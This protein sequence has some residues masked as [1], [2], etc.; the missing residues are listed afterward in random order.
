M[1]FLIIFILFAPKI[2]AQNYYADIEITV[3]EAGNV[4]IQ[5]TSNYPDLI[6][7]NTEKYTYKKQSY[8]LL[9]ITKEEVFSDYIYT[10]NLPKGSKINY[11]ESSGFDGIEE[12][13]GQLIITGSGNDEK[14]SIL[15]QYQIDGTVNEICRDDIILW[16]LFML[17]SI[18]RKEII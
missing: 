2:F 5:G 14:L 12:E 16:I 15:V 1:L 4:D 3:D 6:I 7:E 11:I 13:D 18:L 9:N 17:I 8:W 10:L